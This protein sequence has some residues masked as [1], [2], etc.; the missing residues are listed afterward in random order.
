MATW[1]EKCVCECGG[2][3]CLPAVGQW[4][5]LCA[6]LASQ[7][8]LSDVPEE[9]WESSANDLFDLFFFQ[10]HIS[11]SFFSTILESFTTNN[12]LRVHYV[13]VSRLCAWLCHFIFVTFNFFKPMFKIVYPKYKCL[14]LKIILRDC[15][16]MV[17][18]GRVKL[19]MQHG[20]FNC[21]YQIFQC[22]TQ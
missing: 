5:Q 21:H 6:W 9:R 2:E 22:I 19:S 4:R 14:I 10:A 13:L 1:A 18:S 3:I 7:S 20:C 17:S 16:I 8:V 12:L 15:R 11:Q